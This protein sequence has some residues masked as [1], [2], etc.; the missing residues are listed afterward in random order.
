MTEL[1]TTRLDGIATFDTVTDTPAGEVHLGPAG[2]R[3]MGLY[4]RPAQTVTLATALLD[5]AAGLTDHD[6]HPA[7][8]SELADRI[9]PRTA[10]EIV[11]NLIA[12]YGADMDDTVDRDTLNLEIIND[13]LDPEEL[14]TYDWNIDGDLEDQ[15][16]GEYAEAVAFYSN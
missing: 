13:R 3:S 14:G 12:N 5:H 11:A 16:P 2:V 4:L 15:D 1:K 7:D 8:L 10:Q 9:N 6:H